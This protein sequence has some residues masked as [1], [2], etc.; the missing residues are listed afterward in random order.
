MPLMSAIP[1]HRSSV[2]PIT[3][4]INNVEGFRNHAFHGRQDLLQELHKFFTAPANPPFTGPACTILHGLGGMGKTAAA[5]E[6]THV[7]QNSFDAIFWLRAS[8]ESELCG[9][10]CAIARKLKLNIESEK[11]TFVIE[12]IKEWLEGTSK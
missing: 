1:S 4:P 3:F 6:Y 10:Y 11:E 2:S 12:E 8:S 7:F 5:R 9:S